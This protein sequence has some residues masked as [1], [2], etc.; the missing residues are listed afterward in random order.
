L[1]KTY[2]ETP[3]AYEALWSLAVIEE[4]N[5][6]LYDS[7][8]VIYL[9]VSRRKEEKH[10]LQAAIN[11]IAVAQR[12]PETEKPDTGK[13]TE[14]DKKV[15]ETC[16]NY[17]KLFPDRGDETID[18][19]FIPASTYFNRKIY[20]KALSIYQLIVA[21]A[22]GKSDPKAMEALLYAGQCYVGM[23]DYV[24]AELTF[25]DLYAAAPEGKY[26]DEAK[27][28][29]VEA[30]FQDAEEKRF[31]KDFKTAGELFLRIE[32]KYPYYVNLDIVL[33][34]A[35][36]AFEK[37]KDWKTAAEVYRRIPEK[38]QGS[39]LADGALFNGAICFE[40]D[41]NYAEAILNYE[42]LLTNYPISERAKDALYNIGLCYERMKAYDKMAEAQERY[43]E[44]YPDSKEVEAMLFTSAK[45]FN[46]SGKLDRA[47]KAYEN[48]VRRYPGSAGEIEC[49]FNLAQILFKEGDKRSSE[50]AFNQLIER[51]TVLSAIGKNNDYYSAEAAFRLADMVRERY[52]AVRFTL[53]PKIMEAQQKDKADLLKKTVEA[54]SRV[55]QLKSERLFEAAYRIGEAYQHFAD[56]YTQQERDPKMETTKQVVFERDLNQAAVDLYEKS[57]EP[58]LVNINLSKSVKRD[59]LKKEQLRFVDLSRQAV[60]QILLSQG[61]FLERTA[62]V[63]LNS[64]VPEKI[65]RQPVQ[66]YLYQQK[67]AETVLPMFNQ[68][69]DKYVSTA[70]RVKEKNLGDSLVTALNDSLARVLFRRGDLLEKLSYE[71]L[72]NPQ[73]PKEL[74]PSEKEEMA[75]QLED[76]AFE[77]QDKALKTFEEGYNYLNDQNITNR[78]K[79]K[80]LESLKTLDPATYTPKEVLV[81]VRTGTGPDWQ[82][83]ADSLPL[84]NKPSRADTLWGAA[85]VKSV[86]HDTTARLRDYQAVGRA[87][88]GGL[89]YLRRQFFLPGKVTVASVAIASAGAYKLFINGVPIAGDTSKSRN[90]LRV[91][92]FDVKS[93]LSG[94]DNALCAWVV[95]PDNNSGLLVGLTAVI[96]TSL[97]YE[98]AFGLLPPV[99]P[100]PRVAPADTSGKVKVAAVDSTKKAKPAAADTS[101]KAK[102]AP[103]DTSAKVKVAVVDSTNKI[104]PAAVDSSAKVKIAPAPAA[105]P[106]PA[107]AASSAAAPAPAST[108]AAKSAPVAAPAPAPAPVPPPPLLAA[109]KPAEAAKPE[110]KKAKAEP[111]PFYKEFKNYGEFQAAIQEAQNRESEAGKE[112]KNVQTRIRGIKYRIRAVEDNIKSTETD[113]KVYQK[114][115][116]SKER[117]R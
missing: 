25:A 1:N 80:I 16:Q 93:F 35:A 71:M 22:K 40:N 63:L 3:E 24:N 11:A 76:I 78:W 66:Y 91:D 104:K 37:Q 41:S 109:A 28:R 72:N 18:V 43:A 48:F 117:R 70:A 68:A 49:R 107:P 100:A 112:I 19:A 2:P 90:P 75:F 77:I 50:D 15:V 31:K 58:H 7:A 8:R 102:A 103:A 110:E 30:A 57:I 53:P 106:P 92:S 97:H 108:P 38:F 26:K 51:N 23:K 64:P 5:L 89:C 65:K 55:I 6:G 87:Q 73:M 59:S 36:D 34:N 98:S 42:K 81:T 69:I 111:V 9:D 67:L 74:K 44:R 94:G 116:E 88:G 60:G 56:V 113:I 79:Q 33:F 20:P 82:A 95:N 10:K 17:V 27:T 84:W 45:F 105:V 85:A 101:A 29:Q 47:K 14:R 13:L 39:K 4:Q 12:L 32:Q 114:I 83:R 96:D 86:P 61:S 99:P 52:M 62:G 21:K 46:E 115:L 54:Y